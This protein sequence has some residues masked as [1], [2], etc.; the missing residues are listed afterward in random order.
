MS[1]LSIV[2][3]LRPTD[4]ALYDERLKIRIFWHAGILS[5][6]RTD[7]LANLEVGH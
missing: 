1:S 5:A 4:A 2:V 7:L 3:V 6:L